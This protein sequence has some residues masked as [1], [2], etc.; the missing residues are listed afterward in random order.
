MIIEISYEGCI[1]FCFTFFI[2]IW[3]GLPFFTGLCKS[4]S[5]KEKEAKNV[6]RCCPVL[7]VCLSR[8]IEVCAESTC[9]TGVCSSTSSILL[10]ASLLRPISFRLFTWSFSALDYRPT[11]SKPQTS[12]FFAFSLLFCGSNNRNPNHIIVLGGFAFTVFALLSTPL[13]CL[14][15]GDFQDV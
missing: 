11:R 8:Q 10:V 4:N 12:L 7:V 6:T 9:T 1:P 13:Q 15:V 2:I 3:R 14:V 5:N